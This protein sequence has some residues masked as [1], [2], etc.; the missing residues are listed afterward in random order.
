MEAK[1]ESRFQEFKD[2][3]RADLQALLGQYFCPPPATY[4][5]KGKGVLGVL[6]GFPCKEI[7]APQVP[8]GPTLADSGSVHRRTNHSG[9]K[10]LGSQAD[11]NAPCSMAVISG[12]GGLN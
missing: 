7:E 2:K 8:V 12:A 3:F 1:I 11:L 6:L 4:T 10:Y 5:N 9:E